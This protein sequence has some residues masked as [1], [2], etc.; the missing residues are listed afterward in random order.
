MSAIRNRLEKNDK[1]IRPWAT[2]LN[3]EAYRL[4][5]LDIPEYPFILDRYKDNL[6]FWDRS[7]EHIERDRARLKEAKDMILDYFQIPPSLLVIKERDR[8]RGTTQYEKL[9]G[10]GNTF[11]VQEGP[12]KFEV[13]LSDYLD[14]GLFLDHRPLR[15]R[16]TS[17]K[18]P[19]RVLNLFC[20]TGSLSVAAAK[21]GAEVTSIDMSATYLE[22]AERNFKHNE[23][24]PSL[25]RF[26]RH[27]LMQ[28][29]ASPVKDQYDL[30]LLDPPTFSNSKKMEKSF[31]VERDQEFLVESCM[32]RLRPGGFL[33]FSNNKRKFKLAASIQDRYRWFD[34]TEK[35]IPMDFKGA[36]PHVCFE[37]RK[38][39]E[40]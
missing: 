12:L 29:L 18:N 24:D 27:D 19:G 32:S 1:K 25:H 39:N 3:F 17:M 23:L 16:L 14:T 11:L 30:I 40:A 22:W 28:Y 37:I 4:Y 34:I 31:E 38:K 26:F 7:N 21:A 6:V 9:G 35:S 20:Y 5:D 15:E 2:R 36:A 8:Q 33:I 13:N 10:S